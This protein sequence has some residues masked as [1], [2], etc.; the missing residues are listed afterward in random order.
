MGSVPDD[1]FARRF[2]HG[3]VEAVDTSSETFAPGEVY[4]FVDDRA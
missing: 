3:V 4:F 2:P 1:F